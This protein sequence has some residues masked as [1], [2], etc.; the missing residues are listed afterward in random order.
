[1]TS[2]LHL[3]PEALF[4]HTAWMRGLARRL[5]LSDERADDVVQEAWRAALERPHRR[6]VPLRAWLAGIVRNQ[7]RFL[8]RSEGRRAGREA[9][10][11]RP[12]VVSSTA[13]LAACADEQRRLLQA[14]LGLPE[15]Y[16][17]V[18]LLRFYDGLEPR[19]IAARL[20]APV[21]TVRTRLQRALERLRAELDE[22]H[23][24]DRSAW[25][26]AL[27]PLMGPES[28]AVA[29]SAVLATTIFGTGF[30]AL[31][32]LSLVGLAVLVAFGLWRS[33]RPEPV[34]L[35]R[36]TSP[37]EA[38]VELFGTRELV[39]SSLDGRRVE[40][41]AGEAAPA[42]PLCTIRGL[43]VD[44]EGRPIDG[45][46]INM[47]SAPKPETF[48]PYGRDLGAPAWATSAADGSFER[49][50]SDEQSVPW[51]EVVHGDFLAVE[52]STP[53][54][55]EEPTTLRMAPLAHTTLD[56]EVRDRTSGQRAPRF[57]LMASIPLANA[58]EGPAQWT[59]LSAVASAGQNE[60]DV[61]CAIDRPLHLLVDV[62]GLTRASEPESI[63]Q[64]VQPVLHART[65]VRF[66]VDLDEPER[67]AAG[68]VV[69]GRVVDD[70]TN[71]PI[72]GAEVHGRQDADT[73]RHVQSF[74]DGGFRIAL[75]EPSATFTVHHPHYLSA[76]IR[77]DA[78]T[79]SVVRLSRRGSIE[80]T[81]VDRAGD[82]LPG[83][84]LLFLRRGVA[85]DTLER[86]VERLRVATDA[87]GR[88]AFA[89]L[90]PARYHLFALGSPLDPDERALADVTIDLAAG[91][92][93]ELLFS[94]DPPDRI[95]V[96]GTVQPPEACTVALVP[97]FL[98]YAAEG[99]WA[100]AK[101]IEGGYRASGLERGRYL[102]LLAPA[103]DGL[104]GPMALLPDVD[105]TGFGEQRI[106][107]RY[108]AAS[109]RGRVVTGAPRTDLNVVAVP[110][111]PPGFAHDV[112]TTADVAQS[113]AVPV[114]SDGTFLLEWLARGPHRLELRAAGTSSVL[115]TQEVVLEASLTLTDWRL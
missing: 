91:E 14:V 6:D 76:S 101:P 80:G 3:D 48:S 37:I 35:A 68:V 25:C 95:T 62:P 110:I 93:R 10:A 97:T 113:L 34:E 79:E 1:M 81:L 106:D 46:R 7:A 12:D 31:K 42:R 15:A 41:A 108:P 11:A 20:G 94:L 99:G 67:E 13:E 17:D 52:R 5:V 43:V 50:W 57:R 21:N 58:V 60:F 65:T 92:E 26:A 53:A 87:D 104:P 84:P 83:V 54:S 44:L 51:L 72:A 23:D 115:A 96:F 4:E 40:V 112:L 71:E 55:L 30:M 86:D 88:F 61:A 98:P 64:V 24:G 47:V 109:L 33:T 18:V 89:H 105:L 28:P 45:A 74:A 70:A 111:L 16:R 103:D 27:L 77:A 107:F 39:S 73:E 85:A 69:R 8:R 32:T 59:A 38:A 36:H 90:A 78:P 75:A 22:Q 102:V 114:A 29:S 100:S 9:V 66:V 56:V 63:R 82:P 49:A 2:P 19:H